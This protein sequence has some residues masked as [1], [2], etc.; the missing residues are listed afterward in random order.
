[1][2]DG[3][4]HHS[5]PGTAALLRELAAAHG[6]GTSY[7]GWDGVERS[8]PESTLRGVLAALGVPAADTDAMERSLD[9]A[10]LA[11]WRRLLPPVAVAREGQELLI[12]VHVP[13]GSAVSVWI[14]AE[15]GRRPLRFQIPQHGYCRRT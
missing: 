10:R 6:V 12:N 14:A 8:V 3:M 1:M 5:S 13:H 9:E 11:P 7:W 2:A 4:H 15:D